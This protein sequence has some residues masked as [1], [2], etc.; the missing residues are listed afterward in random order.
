MEEPRSLTPTKM[1]APAGIEP[2][3]EIPKTRDY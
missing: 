1:F 3:K 2:V